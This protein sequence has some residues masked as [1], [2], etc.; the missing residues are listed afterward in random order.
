M[1]M[2]H[3]PGPVR[4]FDADWTQYRSR[5]A[6][7]GRDPDRT[8]R[9]TPAMKDAHEPARGTGALDTASEGSR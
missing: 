1:S 4:R 3:A 8:P 9:R 7:A 6:D 2:P 5:L